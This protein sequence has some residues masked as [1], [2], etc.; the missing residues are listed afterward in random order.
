MDIPAGIVTYNPDL[1]RLK[2]NIDAVYK[3]A[4]IIIIYDN[5]SNNKADIQA[6]VSEYD[7]IVLLS[8]EENKGIAV[9]LNQLCS[10]AFDRKYLYILT[11]DQD[12]V[13]P[14]NLFSEFK[15]YTDNRNTG[16]ICP[17]IKDRNYT[18][19]AVNNTA[20]TEEI[21]RCITS[22]SLVM[23]K[24]WKEING[25]DES[26]FIDGVDF[27]FCDRIRLKGYTILRVNNVVLLHEIGNIKI[28][29][30]LF[31]KVIVKNHSAF[32]KYYISRNT[33]YL[34]RKKKRKSLVFKARLQVIKQYMT[35]LFYEEDKK[36]KLHEIIR[37]FKDGKRAVIDERWI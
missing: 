6:L 33:V 32:R 14:D 30:F 12:S 16:V 13:C 18:S 19:K 31:L 3:E 9:A 20:E 36:K 24:A 1:E 7:R 15:K 8:N 26:M 23:L 28:R 34:A 21:G 5:G 10:E 27:D 11:L 4:A 22:G 2:E 35:V 29:H 25:F 37:G 17:A